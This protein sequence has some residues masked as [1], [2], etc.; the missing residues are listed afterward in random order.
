MTCV[1]HVGCEQRLEV[2]DGSLASQHSHLIREPEA[3]SRGPNH[4]ESSVICAGMIHPTRPAHHELQCE[5]SPMTD[6]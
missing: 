2:G 1:T 4:G 3:E 6:P 5:P